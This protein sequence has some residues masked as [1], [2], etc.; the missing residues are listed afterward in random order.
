MYPPSAK[1]PFVIKLLFELVGG[2]TD[3]Q[4]TVSDTAHTLSEAQVDEAALLLTGRSG[5]RLPIVYVTSP[6]RGMPA[7]DTETLSASLAGLALVVV[8]PSKYFSFAL[9]RRMDGDN[10]YGGA[11][12]IVWPHAA[13]NLIRLI[14]SPGDSP[15]LVESRI[16][17]QVRVALTLTRPSVEITWA[18]LRELLSRHRIDKLKETGSDQVEAYVSEF[19]V[20]LRAKEQRIAEAEREIFRL[21]SELHKS[22]SNGQ[23][24]A[25]LVP[26]H[27][28][29]YYPGELRDAVAQALELASRS[30]ESGSRRRHLIDDLRAVNPPSGTDESI[31]DEIKAA[32]ATRGDLGAGQ[33]ALLEQLGFVITEEGKHYK[34]VYQGDGRYTFSISKTSSDRRA[35]KN[36]ASQI[37]RTLFK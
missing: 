5:A 9:A 10:P 16:I 8:E 13:G 27:E 18:F 6:H 3:G 14:P 32:F 15:S 12:G 33:R 36:L 24:G 29:D 23:H 35:G 30:L 7:L 34:A 2:G 19:D 22:A 25:L 31:A 1:K 17:D 37:N 21:N 11:I 4:F 28:R 20:E 26:G